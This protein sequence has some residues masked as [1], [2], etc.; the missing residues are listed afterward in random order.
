MYKNEITQQAHIFSD[1]LF[2]QKYNFSFYILVGIYLCRYIVFVPLSVEHT[3]TIIMHWGR[4]HTLLD[5][6]CCTMELMVEEYFFILV[7]YNFENILLAN[8]NAL[9]EKVKRV[10][11]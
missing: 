4:E 2:L 9:R 8:L 1:R 11:I 10:L 3:L 6:C 7:L 5:R